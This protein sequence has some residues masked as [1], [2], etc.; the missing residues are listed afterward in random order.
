MQWSSSFDSSA[1]PYR[2]P[3]QIKDYLAANGQYPQQWND[4]VV[5]SWFTRPSVSSTNGTDTTTP[6]ASPSSAASSAQSESSN[7]TGSI[8]GGVIGGVGG[9]VLIACLAW[10]VVRRRRRTS[11]S[12][13][14]HHSSSK[15]TFEKAELDSNHRKSRPELSGDTNGHWKANG[16]SRELTSTPVME[17]EGSPAEYELPSNGKR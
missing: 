8:A 14:E 5:E 6:A 17:M 1:G 11:E 12:Q 13:P 2:T 15:H 4:D 9:V 3:Q 10:F 16:Q 7:D